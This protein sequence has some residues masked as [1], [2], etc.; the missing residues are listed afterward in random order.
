[1][2]DETAKR[3]RSYGVISVMLALIAFSLTMSAIMIAVQTSKVERIYDVIF[4]V[5]AILVG[6]CAP[7]AHVIGVGLGVA[8]IVRAGDR[9]GLGVLGAALNTL[10]IASALFFTYLAVAGSGAVR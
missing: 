10:A 3:R 8:A 6:V 9:P 2:A 4:P 7:L 5:L 1:M